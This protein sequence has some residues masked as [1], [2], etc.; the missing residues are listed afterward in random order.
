MKL[1]TREIEAFLTRPRPE[2]VTALLYGPDAGLVAERARCLALKVVEMLDDP[3]RVSELDP[4]LIDREPARLV[5]EAQALCL[6]GGRRLVRVRG[7]D[8]RLA[9]AL[10]D[11]LALPQQEGFVLI[12]AGELGG[13]SRL[14]R[15]V[16]AAASAV[17]LPCYR[18]DERSLPAFIR[19]TL[20]ELGLRV[21]AEAQAWLAAN[22]GGDRAVTRRELEKLALYMGGQSRAVTLEDAAAIVGD[23]AAIEIDDMVRAALTGEG[24]RLDRTLD[25]LLAEGVTPSS[26]LRAASRILLQAVR[27]KGEVMAGKPSASALAPLHFRQRD[28]FETLLRDWSADRLL[29]ALAR[30]QDAEMRARRTGSPEE[31]ICRE[32]LTDL[33]RP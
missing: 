3:F 2:V 30:L 5:E 9:K 10:K 29:G 32:V 25:R 23:S 16:E 27:I 11:L 13:G 4:D 15:A 18:A 17:A 33:A 31:L 22:L 6:M 20:G 24:R 26:L 7:A 8:D 28:L 19:E 12:E 1:A 14:R 21:E